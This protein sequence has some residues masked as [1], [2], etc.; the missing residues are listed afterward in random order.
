[1]PKTNLAG[2]KKDKLV[3]AEKNGGNEELAPRQKLFWWERIGALTKT[4]LAG[5][6]AP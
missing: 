5:T 6:L 2:K 4:N 3:G 1:M